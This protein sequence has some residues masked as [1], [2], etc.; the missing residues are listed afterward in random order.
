MLIKETTTLARLALQEELRMKQRKEN[1]AELSIVSS[2]EEHLLIIGH[3]TC[4][5]VTAAVIYLNMKKIPV[6]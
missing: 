6:M 5:D 3:Y 1:R 2:A 4:L